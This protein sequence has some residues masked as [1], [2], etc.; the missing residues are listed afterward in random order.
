MRAYEFG[1]LLGFLLLFGGGAALLIFGSR[2]LP[3]W[4]P[5]PGADPTAPVTRGRRRSRLMMVAGWVLIAMS[6]LGQ[7]GQQ[8]NP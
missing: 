3:P 1:R 4:S 5:E 8:A 6:I 7:L 2:R